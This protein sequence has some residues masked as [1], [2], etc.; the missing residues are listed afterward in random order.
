MADTAGATVARED[1]NVFAAGLKPGCATLVYADPPFFSGKVRSNGKSG[2]AYDDR[3]PG[4]LQQYL[5]FLRG[6]IESARPVLCER[7]V[8]ALHLDWRA[9]HY[10]RIEL[11]RAFGADRFVNEII[12][13]YRTGGLSRNR[14]GRKHDTI[15]VFAKGRQHKFN[16]IR[17]KSYLSHHYGY[18]NVNIEEDEQGPYTLA[19]LRDVW[20][21]PALRGNQREYKGYPTQKP[22]TLLSRLIECFTDRGDIVVDLCCGSGTTLVAATRAGRVAMGCDTGAEAVKL[23]RRRLSEEC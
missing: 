6:L 10:A 5:A 16:V 1:A 9:S 13:S 2:P 19:A 20:E 18:S 21:I 15:L 4:G 3:W 8:I 23:A 22:L 11:E 17:E 14:L 12:W 7:G